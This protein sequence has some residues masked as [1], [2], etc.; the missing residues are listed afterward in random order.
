MGLLVFLDPEFLS[1]RSS[2]VDP[3]QQSVGREDDPHLLSLECNLVDLVDHIDH[4]EDD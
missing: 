3:R 1:Y 2:I 4:Q